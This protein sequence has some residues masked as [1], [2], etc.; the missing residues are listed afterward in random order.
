[1]RLLVL[2]IEVV[3]LLFRVAW[4]FAKNIDSYAP[5]AM[6][7]LSG[8]LSDGFTKPVTIDRIEKPRQASSK[9]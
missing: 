2:S 9:S 3:K 7:A 8:L 4:Q 1:M 5:K 6:A